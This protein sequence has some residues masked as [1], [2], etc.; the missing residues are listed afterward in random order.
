MSEA[1]AN[2]PQGGEVTPSAE[3]ET[4][5]P[6]IATEVEAEL[7]DDGNPIE[8]EP[9]EEETEEVVRGEKKYRIPKALSGELL[10]QADYTRKTQEVAETK[11]TLEDR[12]KAFDE[13]AAQHQQHI[14]D[15]AKLVG[16]N[17]QVEAFQK[18][19]WQAYRAQYG[20]EATQD[21]QFQY[22]NIQK[23]RDDAAGQLQQ[24]IS[25]QTLDGQ[26][27][28]AKAAEESQAVL[29]RDIKGWSPELHGKLKDLAQTVGGYTKSEMD[30]VTDPRALKVLHRL[31][32]GEAAIKELAALKKAK[33]AE[34]VQPLP[35]VNG[36]AKARKN[37]DDMSMEEWVRYENNRIKAKAQRRA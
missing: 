28:S 29:A 1:H 17:E 37:P 34:E 7:D 22:Q 18:F 33:S 30:G 23:A 26:R 32:Q 14:K 21:L 15:V 9:E 8:A 36:Q 24:K 5:T 31:S 16:L 12:Q 4:T 27:A 35:Q 6:A 13:Q 10:M 2:N 19:D 3:L 25:Q 20:V 11:R